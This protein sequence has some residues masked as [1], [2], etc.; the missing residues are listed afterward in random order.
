MDLPDVCIIIYRPVACLAYLPIYSRRTATSTMYVID[1]E[2]N[3][4]HF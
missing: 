2:C 4:L 1:T 3:I